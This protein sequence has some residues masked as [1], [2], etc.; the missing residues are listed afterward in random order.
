MWNVTP[1]LILTST[2]GHPSYRMILMGQK[3]NHSAGIRS[4]TGDGVLP[5]SLFSPAPL[6]NPGSF[7]KMMDV[8]IVQA[9]VGH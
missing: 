3:L 5:I 9:A 6:E 7:G 4:A 8:S 1:S 2:P